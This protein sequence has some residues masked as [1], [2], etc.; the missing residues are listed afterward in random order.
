MAKSLQGCKIAVLALDGFEQAE[1]VEPKRALS[2]E[3]ATVHVISAKPG[4]IQGFKHVDKGDAV[5]VDAT[6]DKATAAEYDAV[7]LPGGV[8]NGDAIRLLP[9]AQ[10]FV[11]A[12]NQAHKPIAVICHG[13]WL[14]VSAGIMKGRTVTSWPS[15][16]DDIRNAGGTWVDQ[17]V[18]EDDNFITSRKPD[19]LPAFNKTL[20]AQL[21][22]RKAA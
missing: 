3:G 4:K 22:K 17:E 14:P 19:D 1:L 20:I 5:E 15:L 13:A 12:A 10:A 2:A 21:T 16:Q 18:V 9:Q 7:V 11:K 6:F 8:V